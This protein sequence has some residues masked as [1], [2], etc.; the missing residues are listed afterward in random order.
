MRISRHEPW[1]NVGMEFNVSVSSEPRVNLV[2]A[3]IYGTVIVERC[4]FE[5]VNFSRDNNKASS[6]PVSN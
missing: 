2:A 4:I 6:F 1:L 3:V 5:N